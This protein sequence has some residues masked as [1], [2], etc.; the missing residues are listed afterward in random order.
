MKIKI[1]ND[2]FEITQRIKKIDE[3][4]FI[5]FDTLKQRFELHNSEQVNT[6]CLTVPYDNLDDRLIDLVMYSKIDNIDNIINEIDINNKVIEGKSI[7]KLKDQTGY[8]IREIYNFCNNSS[9]IYNVNSLDN[10]WR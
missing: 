2:V 7:N 10:V 8:M 3:G 9:K 5:V 1:E 4:Y 6:Y